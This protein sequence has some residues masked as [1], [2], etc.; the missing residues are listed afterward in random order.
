MTYLAPALSL[1]NTFTQIGALVAFAALV[2]IARNLVRDHVKKL[3][4]RGHTEDLTDTLGLSE[5]DSAT[6]VDLHHDLL[7]AMRHLTDDQ[8]QVLYHRFLQDRPVAET[9]VLMNRSEDAVKNLQ[10]RALAAMHQA[11]VASGYAEGSD[12]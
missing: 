7:A 8:Q 11:M 9:A 6:G 1:S 10:R 12:Q 2:G 3:G 4:R 5:P